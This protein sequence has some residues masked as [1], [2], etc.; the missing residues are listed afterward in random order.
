[1]S[2]ET[3]DP[4]SKNI[5]TPNFFA[6]LMG[7]NFLKPNIISFQDEEFITPYSEFVA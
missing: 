5:I 2:W 4:L 1:M 3:L 7:M 6:A